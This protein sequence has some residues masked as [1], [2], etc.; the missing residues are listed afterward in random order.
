MAGTEQ[1]FVVKAI[2]DLANSKE[3]LEAV[4]TDMESIALTI[5]IETKN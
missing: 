5:N 4:D 2:L 1:Q 3:L